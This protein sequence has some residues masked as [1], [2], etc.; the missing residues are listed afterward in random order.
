MDDLDWDLKCPCTED[1][2]RVSC[3]SMM[4]KLNLG[5]GWISRFDLPERVPDDQQGNVLISGVVQ[6]LVALCFYHI[7]I[8]DY[9]RLAVKR[10]QAFLLD[11]EDA[12]VCL[13]INSGGFFNRLCMRMWVCGRILKKQSE[14]PLNRVR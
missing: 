2:I 8:C 13:E 3:G 12:S 7:T 5:R 10:F 14:R 11:Q 6:D 9:Q 1:D 4:N